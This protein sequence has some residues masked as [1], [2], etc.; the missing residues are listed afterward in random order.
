MKPMQWKNFFREMKSSLNRYLSILFIVALGVAFYSG[1]RSA[2]PDMRLSADTYYDNQNFF[3]VRVMGSYGMTQEDVEEIQKIGGVS[4]AQGAYTA[5]AVW[6]S[7]EEEYVCTLYS[8]A[9]GV[10]QPVI[11]QGRLPQAEDE[12]FLDESINMLRDEPYKLGDQ[13]TLTS[14]TEEP[15][16]DTLTNDT[17]T[18]VGIGTYPYYLSWDR[19]S[20]Q[21][22]DGTADCFVLLPSQVFK[23][24]VYTQV[25]L[26]TDS[27]DTLNSFS[28][29]YKEKLD[30]I[31]SSIENIAGQR[32]E[33]RYE[34]VL[35]SAQEELEQAKTDLEEAK[36][37]S[38]EEL[39][40]ALEQIEDGETQLSQGRTELLEKEKQLAEGKAELEQ[41]ERALEQSQAQI[42]AQREALLDGELELLDGWAEYN[43]SLSQYHNG[44]QMLEMLKPLQEYW[45]SLDLSGLEGEELEQAIQAIEQ[46]NS[47]VAQLEASLPEA[48]AKLDAAYATL[49]QKQKELSDGKMQ[50]AAAQAQ[51]DMG[52]TQLESAR[53][54]IADGEAQIE[55]G[56]QTLE[57]MEQQ[58]SQAR[59]DY[60]AGKQE[61]E[62]QI[63]NGEEEIAHG[64]QELNSMSYPEWYVLDRETVQTYVEYG[65]DAER[66]GAIGKVFPAIFF[67]VAALVSLTTMTRMVEDERTMIGTMKALGYSR[68]SIAAK[69][70]LYAL[71]A[72]IFGSLLGIFV[73]GKLLPYVIMSAYGILY[74]N[75]PVMLV[76]IQW[77]LSIIASL[78]A[79]LC[80]VLATFFACYKELLSTPASLMRPAAPKQGKRIFLEHIPFLWRRL[81]FSWKATVR[82]LLR[83][84]KRFFMTL[85]GI[86]GCMALLLVGFGLRDSIQ[87]I[88][89]KQYSTIWTYDGSVTLEEGS[90]SNGG[91]DETLKEYSNIRESMYVYQTSL[92]ASAEGETDRSV[93]LFV[94]GDM[95]EYPEFVR[96]KDRVSG[97]EEALSDEGAVISEKLA[98]L[99]NLSVGDELT[100][101][102][103]E[104]EQYTVTVADI[105]ENYLYHYVYMT[106]ALY[107]QVFGKEPEYNQVFL[108]MEDTSPEAEERLGQTLLEEENVTSVSFVSALQEKVSD[109]MSSMDLVIW[110]LIISAGLLAFVVLYNLN[111]INISERQREMATLKVLGFYDKEVTAYV[112]RENILLTIIGAAAGVILGIFLHQFVIRT[113]E[114]DMIMFGRSI[115]PLS[116]VLS[117]A[118]TFVFSA[119]VNV[120][121]YYKLKK[122][123]MIESLKSVE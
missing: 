10:N 1:V 114:I 39:S 49:S 52:K 63:S 69:Y 87:E 56:R 36:T 117:V 120:A 43:S 40:A 113:C 35:G 55:E 77:D 95:E 6:Q 17:F 93:Y 58:L 122:I 53:Q 83:Y 31:K 15:L 23:Q 86:G 51:V 98:S 60:E 70:I 44:V 5:E 16:S 19:G 73:G 71:S 45:N 8:L 115:R 68:G 111:N 66:I 41:T 27:L 42:D 26:T 54:E 30:R 88:V 25:Y 59:E 24:E 38:E 32:C 33:I 85:F 47:Q 119:M 20:A 76:P 118:L 72:S 65:T 103:G 4:Q 81:N 101:K 2:E 7:E 123:D 96:L 90:S 82:N 12:C 105:T 3:D 112:Y 29:E 14:G 37:T 48:K 21:I 116:Y 67:L 99:L 102:M 107:E 104:T 91:F 97:R 34:E 61:A 57:E 11:S 84:K 100:L 79:V 80:T 92:D 46:V 121:M 75:L 110:V 109:M 106:P 78:I 9:E 64:E 13:I 18:V 74:T 62:E 94:P 28:D 22:G 108:K 50:L 89:N